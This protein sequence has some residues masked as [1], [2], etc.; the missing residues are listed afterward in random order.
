MLHSLAHV[1][2][3]MLLPCEVLVVS[4]VCRVFLPLFSVRA[5]V[6][7]SISTTSVRCH[8]LALTVHA[9]YA[10]VVTGV[11]ICMPVLC[12]FLTVTLSLVCHCLCMFAVRCG[13]TPNSQ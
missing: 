5:R 1:V 3:C 2:C 11:H 8:I 7:D 12:V 9:L 13:V 6:C 4:L 10:S